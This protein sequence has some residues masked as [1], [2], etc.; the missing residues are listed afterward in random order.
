MN[1]FKPYLL[2]QL[3]KL[4]EKSRKV[5]LVVH[6]HPDGDA[7]GSSLGLAL[8]LSEKRSLEVAV[9]LPDTYPQNLSFMLGGVNV[10][11]A[12][13]Q[14]DEA[15]AYLNSCDLL[16][17]LDMNSFSR[18][19]ILE[20]CLSGV[21]STK[22]LIDHHMEPDLNSFDLTFSTNEI[23]STS[24]LVY[25]LIREMSDVEAAHDI[26]SAALHCLMVG[27]TT[28]TNNFS[29][30]VFPSTFAMASELLAAGVDRD[31]ILYHLY[32]QNRENRYRALGF[33]LSNVLKITDEGVAYIVLSKECYDSFG[34][35]DGETEGFVNIPLEMSQVKMS[36][37][38]R[39][40]NGHYRVSIR[41]KEG[42][43]ARGLAKA[44]FNGGGHECASGG[45]L[46][47]PAD[48]PV[49]EAAEQY[50]E[51]VTARFLQDESPSK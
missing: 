35:M 10:I 14:H 44:Y 27:M 28:D 11:I 41:S 1:V 17:C 47:F 20:G 29:N 5:A 3:D 42:Y 43:S 21:K 18:A 9:L 46:Y 8:Y 2:S 13:K 33:I 51:T 32:K 12:D 31:K 15:K 30:S 40:D 6:T 48:I 37:L 25:W 36:L 49:K 4:F 24:E 7:L 23:S 45:K 19:A 26:P 34:L 22:V 39:E 50:V 16:L 38:L